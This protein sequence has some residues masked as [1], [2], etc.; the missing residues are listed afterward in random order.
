M[1]P[2]VHRYGVSRRDHTEASHRG[3]SLEIER[4]LAVAIEVTDALDAAHAK[5]II[6][7]DIKPANIFISKRGHAKDTGLLDWPKSRTRQ[8]SPSAAIPK[9]WPM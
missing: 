8:A 2:S 4:W 6:H 7:R 5:G 9:P 1:K 3:P